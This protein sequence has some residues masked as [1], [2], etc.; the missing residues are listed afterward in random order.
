MILSVPTLAELP[1]STG[2]E[3]KMEYNKSYKQM[4]PNN[5]LL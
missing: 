3:A 2:Y 4:I 5:F 1:F